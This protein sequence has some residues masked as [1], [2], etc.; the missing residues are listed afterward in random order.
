MGFSLELLIETICGDEF[1]WY[2]VL[3]IWD[4]LIWVIYRTHIKQASIVESFYNNLHLNTIV[5]IIQI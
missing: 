3:P 2:L 5:T 4:I 1:K